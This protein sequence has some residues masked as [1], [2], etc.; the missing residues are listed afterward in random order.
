MPASSRVTTCL[1]YDGDGEDAAR[2]YVSLIPNSRI[3]HVNRYVRSGDA[4]DGATEPPDGA[5]LVVQFELDGAKFWALNGGPMFQ[6]NEAA[7][8]VMACDTQAEIDRLWSALSDGGAALECGWVKDR[9]GLFWQIVPAQ[10]DGWM[11]SGDPAATARMHHAVWGMK[12]L[13]I[14]ALEAAFRGA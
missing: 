1:W 12:K 5:A 10:M 3:T 9:F 14:A 6:K 7:S 13:D 4:P 11:A 2:F 8:I